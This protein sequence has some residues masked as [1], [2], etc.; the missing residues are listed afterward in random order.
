MIKL[1]LL[2]ILVPLSIHAQTFTICGFNWDTIYI[3]TD[4]LIRF[5]NINCNPLKYDI[6]PEVT[7][8]YN[9]SVLNILPSSQK[10]YRLSIYN[11]KNAP[12]VFTLYSQRIT[13][14]IKCLANTLVPTDTKVIKKEVAKQLRGVKPI[15]NC[16]WLREACVILGFN[17][18]IERNKEIIYVEEITGWQLSS[19]SKTALQKITKGSTIIFEN[20][21]WKCP[22]DDAGGQT[23]IVLEIE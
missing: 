23:D 6:V 21:N 5:N 7:S 18:R 17:F 16:P 8:K 14:D 2:Y 3:G 22:G 4:N 19:N 15:V 9:D 12:I 11:G 13:L 1:L 20:I 10:K